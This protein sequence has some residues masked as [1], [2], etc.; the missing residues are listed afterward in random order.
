MRQ[1]QF[2]HTK[3]TKKLWKRKQIIIQ[4]PNYNN[5]QTPNINKRIPV[6]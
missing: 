4:K 6:Y 5:N 2:F 1:E 3:R